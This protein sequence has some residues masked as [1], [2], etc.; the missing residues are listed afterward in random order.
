MIW[1]CRCTLLAW[2]KGYEGDTVKSSPK[3]G[4]MS[5]E[6]WQKAKAI[7][8]TKAD[9]DQFEE[10]T[11]LLGKD[12]P[13]Y[14]TDFQKIKYTEPEVWDA[15]KKSARMERTIRSAP[16]DLTKRKFSQYLLKPGAK[17]ANE[18]FN[19]G[20]NPGDVR[21]LRY[22]V[23]RAFDMRNAKNRRIRDNGAETFDIFMQLGV[24]KKKQFLTGWIID[25]PGERPRI[26]T[27]FRV[28]AND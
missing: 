26:V 12:A 18:F 4:D 21:K 6:E 14:Y 10:Y 24:S 27:A 25:A 28:S 1:N 11:K 17:H 16:C 22:D 13:K 15:L 23:A 2:V 3:M 19:V 20:Y 7:P 9:R 5:F 8:D